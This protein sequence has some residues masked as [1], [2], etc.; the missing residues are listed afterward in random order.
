MTTRGGVASKK[1]VLLAEDTEDNRMVFTFQI[2]SVGASVEA[3]KNGLEAVESFKAHHCDLVLMD[4]QMPVMDGLT[5]T[6][7][8]RQWEQQQGLTPTQ[9]IA[10][11]ASSAKEELQEALAAGC[12]DYLAKPL[13][14]ASLLELFDKTP[15][16]PAPVPPPPVAVPS[17]Q[18][19]QSYRITLDPLLKDL[20]PQ[21][22]STKKKQLAEIAQALEQ[23]D[24]PQIQ[25]LG[26]KLR[27]SHG[28][29]KVNTLSLSLEEAAKQTDFSTAKTLVDQL[30]DYLE[31]VTIHFKEES[32]E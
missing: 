14:R 8:I 20:V 13:T 24:F 7:E 4:L 5:A 32:H 17:P 27:G 11:T 26:H 10:L 21:I 29:E 23:K 3:V 19:A 2:K 6:R 30:T 28:L 25:K 15:A 22:L 31:K 9:I 1:H 16:T 18:E 12:D